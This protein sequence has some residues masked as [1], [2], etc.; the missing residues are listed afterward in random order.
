MPH[1]REA[2]EAS[3]SNPAESV[4]DDPHDPGEQRDDQREVSLEG[5]KLQVAVGTRL[6]AVEDQY[7][8]P[9]AQQRAQL[10]L[11]SALVG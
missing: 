5:P 4:E 8:W 1:R 9:A 6:A 7:H 2:F 10:D 3:H 11:V